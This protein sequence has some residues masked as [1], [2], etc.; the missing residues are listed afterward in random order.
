V[1]IYKFAG[2]VKWT[3][4][5]TV[6]ATI[7]AN[8][9][10]LGGNNIAVGDSDVNTTTTRHPSLLFSVI[11][12]LVVSDITSPALTASLS[13]N[14]LNLS[15]PESTG[16]GFVLQSASS[17][18]SAGTVWNNVTNA[19]TASSGTLSTSVPA[20]NSESYFRLKLL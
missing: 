19:V 15:W 9:I 14:N 1:D 11:D 5:N 7:D 17:L 2:V 3:I 10:S 18:A 13:G 16:S 20:V 12:N 8:A 4:D 6:I